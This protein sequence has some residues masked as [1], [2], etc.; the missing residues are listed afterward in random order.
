MRDEEFQRGVA[1]FNAEEY[2]AAHEVWEELWLAEVEPE[3]TFLQGLIQTA[4][5]FHHFSCENFS[6][7]GSLLASAAVKLRRSAAHHRGIAVESLLAEI[8]WWARMLGE[9]NI[10]GRE[11]LPRISAG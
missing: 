6:G 7:A 4:A 8:I 11:K 3:R 2:F 9:G 5:A 10:P 1:L